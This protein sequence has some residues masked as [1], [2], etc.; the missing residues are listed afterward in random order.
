M[1]TINVDTKPVYMNPKIIEIVERQY[2]AKYLLETQLKAKDGGWTYNPGLIFYTKEKHPEG[3]NYMAV[4]YDDRTSR[5]DPVAHPRT[6]ITNGLSSIDNIVF[7]GLLV[8]G[9][10]MY[11]HFR[12]HCNTD[13]FG[14]LIDGGRDYSR[15]SIKNDNLIKFKVID[16]HFEEYDSNKDDTRCPMGNWRKSCDKWTCVNKC[17]VKNVKEVSISSNYPDAAGSGTGPAVLW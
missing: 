6:M 14:N 9:K 10:V 3:S 12:H 15:F 1:M 7:D 11:S 5:L 16:D 4:F 13:G 17:E 8:N 2:K